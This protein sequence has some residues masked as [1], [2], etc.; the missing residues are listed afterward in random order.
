MLA[1]NDCAPTCGKA[2]ARGK[3]KTDDAILAHDAA[4]GK[5]VAVM[6]YN[7]GARSL[8]ETQAAFARHPEWRGA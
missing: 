3:A 7:L 5:A 4:A 6:L 2:E 1:Q 8:E